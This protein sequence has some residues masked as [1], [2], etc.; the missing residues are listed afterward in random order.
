MKL[1]NLKFNINNRKMK[2]SLHSLVLRNSS[3]HSL[4]SKS[5]QHSEI[6][7]Y[8]Q[9]NKDIDIEVTSFQKLV[10]QKAELL[11][12]M[13][14]EIK[15]REKVHSQR[16]NNS[17]FT[18]DKLKQTEDKLKYRK[19]VLKAKQEAYDKRKFDTNQLSE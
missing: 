7:Q 11:S 2:T 14:N 15:A 4:D 12:Q 5:R 10:T 3:T 17:D 16:R 1:M 18:Q 9:L 6:I 19:T 13:E 8:E